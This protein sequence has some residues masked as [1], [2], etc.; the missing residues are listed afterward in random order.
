M[1]LKKPKK[2]KIIWDN[3]K[4]NALDVIVHADI[5]HLTHLNI[6]TKK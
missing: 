5:V 1:P 4:G 6:L 3:M 2:K